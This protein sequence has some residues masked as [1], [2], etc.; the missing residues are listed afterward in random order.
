TAASGRRGGA[1]STVAWDAAVVARSVAAGELSAVEALDATIARIEATDGRV[2]AFTSRSYARAR[3]EAAAVD[4]MRA[5]GERLPPLA[6]VPFAVKNL[7]DIEGEV[8]L[9]G[10][11]VNRG[12]P[13]AGEDA[14]LVR[15][16]QAAGAVLVGALNMDEYA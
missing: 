14:F 5:R 10:S 16:L 6:G 12:N 8:T 11:I 7:F 4:A 1:V 15:Q 3:T 9:A 13:P 2:N